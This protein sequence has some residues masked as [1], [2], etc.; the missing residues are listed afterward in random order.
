MPTPRDRDFEIACHYIL[1]KYLHVPESDVSKDKRINRSG[2][3]FFIKSG[4][5]TVVAEVKL[6]RSSRV[7]TAWLR[8]AAAQLFDLSEA[9]QAST[10]IL[11]ISA[12]LTAVQ[13]ESLIEIVAVLDYHDLYR[14]AADNIRILEILDSVIPED[15]DVEADQVAGLPDKSMPT[16]RRLD[17]L[18][19]EVKGNSLCVTLRGVPR[20]RGK[21][22]A[23]DYERAV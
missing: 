2:V 14:L 17:I 8:Q 3:D 13:R 11:M 9:F 4:D 6:Y 21:G 23:D 19:Q 1:A 5:E 7:P 10:R 22:A 16:A 15:Q 12:R 20:G 18:H